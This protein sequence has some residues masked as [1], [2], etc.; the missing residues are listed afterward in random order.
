MSFSPFPPHHILLTGSSGYLGGDLLARLTLPSSNL[1]PP[2]AKL[3]ALVRSESQ[4][5]AVRKYGAEPLTFAV[6]NK[7]EVHDAIMKNEITVVFYL[8]DALRCEGQVAFIDALGEVRR[9][10]GREV[11]FLHVSGAKIFSSHAGAPTDVPLLD[12][13]PDLY[14][15]QKNQKAPFGFMQQATE[16]NNTIIELCEAK[17]IKSYIFAPCIVCQYSINCK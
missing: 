7:A 4:A 10:T 3:F 1:L 14:D 15:I 8:I 13:N 2:S 5:T 11:H 12:T 17:G 16:T 9:R 6:N